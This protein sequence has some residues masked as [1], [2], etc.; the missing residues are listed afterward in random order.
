MPFPQI[1]LVVQEIIHSVKGS[2]TFDEDRTVVPFQGHI[3]QLVLLC[4]IERQLEYRES[5][6]EGTGDRKMF[7]IISLGK[8]DLKMGIFSEFADPRKDVVSLNTTHL[9][10]LPSS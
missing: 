8:K 2:S 9:L 1:T 10:Y 7:C 5:V 6:T 3:S 4:L